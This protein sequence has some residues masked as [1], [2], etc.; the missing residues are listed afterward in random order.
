MN[1]GE[2]LKTAL[3]YAGLVILC[4]VFSPGSA[5]SQDVKVDQTFDDCDQKNS[6]KVQGKSIPV[7]VTTRVAL[8]AFTNEVIWFCDGD[9]NRSASDFFFNVVKIRRQPFTDEFKV[10]F[11]KSTAKPDSN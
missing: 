5:V 2:Q 1:Y 10:V 4:I 7:G 3:S 6:L 9:R 8:P 11:L